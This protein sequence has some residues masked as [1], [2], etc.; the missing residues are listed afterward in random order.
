MTPLYATTTSQNAGAIQRLFT[1]IIAVFVSVINE[2][3]ILTAK[4]LCTQG[5]PLN[6][7]L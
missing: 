2:Q 3:F 1:Y 7:S 4:H 5:K 6:A